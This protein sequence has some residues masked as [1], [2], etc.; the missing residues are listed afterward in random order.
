MELFYEDIGKDVLP[1]EYGGS[2]GT[3]DEIQSMTILVQYYKVKILLI[4]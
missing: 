3:V 2:N 1:V 4:L